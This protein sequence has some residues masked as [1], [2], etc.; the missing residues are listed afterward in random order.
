MP[1]SVLAPTQKAWECS[2]GLRVTPREGEA[3][4]SDPPSPR[5][6]L[7]LTSGFSACSTSASQVSWPDSQAGEGHGG[8]ATHAQEDTSLST[9]APISFS[10]A[11][12]PILVSGNDHPQEAGL[13]SRWWKERASPRSTGSTGLGEGEQ[14]EPQVTIFLSCGSATRS[15]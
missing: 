2:P 9:S 10:S 12:R 6:V 8:G 5:C 1:S 15:Q 14:G 11:E 3:F 13:P 7:S 4:L